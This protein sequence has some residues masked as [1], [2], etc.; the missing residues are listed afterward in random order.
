[1]TSLLNK[2]SYQAFVQQALVN[3]Y[4]YVAKGVE[5]VVYPKLLPVNTEVS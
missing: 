3:T 1:M 2:R 5:S 4:R